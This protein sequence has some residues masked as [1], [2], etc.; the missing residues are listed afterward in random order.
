MK[1]EIA[2]YVSKCGIYQQVKVEHQRP[3]G[4]LQPL[5]IPKW[6]WEMI[7]MDFVS[8]L[9]TKKEENDHLRSLNKVRSI[10]TD[11]DDRPSMASWNSGIH[12]L[13]S[14]S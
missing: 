14:G 11:K 6:K 1:R 10:S 4:P 7:T 12:C 13:R 5:Q 8:S 9:P 3:G 2:K